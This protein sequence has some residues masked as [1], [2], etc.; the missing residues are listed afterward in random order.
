MYVCMYIFCYHQYRHDLLFSAVLSLNPDNL[1]L[2]PSRFESWRFKVIFINFFF[3][4]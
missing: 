4:F 2:D 3:G 1:T